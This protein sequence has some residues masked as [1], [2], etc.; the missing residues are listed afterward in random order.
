APLTDVGQMQ[1]AKL[2]ERFSKSRR[3]HKRKFSVASKSGGEETTGEVEVPFFDSIICSPAVR[4][5]ETA[6]I[7]LSTCG[8]RAVFQTPSGDPLVGPEEDKDAESEV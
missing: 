8:V 1:A 3:F 4:T 7:S 2:G 6:R 5:K